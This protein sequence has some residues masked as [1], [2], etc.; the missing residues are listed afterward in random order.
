[1]L[2]NQSDAA[3]AASQEVF[4]KSDTSSDHVCNTRT[5]SKEISYRITHMLYSDHFIIII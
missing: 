3:R 1:M 4:D 5:V 2:K